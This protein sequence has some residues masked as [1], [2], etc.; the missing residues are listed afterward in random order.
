MTAPTPEK[1]D[2]D[3]VVRASVGL[4]SGVFDAWVAV[5]VTGNGV[6]GVEVNAAVK[7]G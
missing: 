2:W 1:P 3:S 7:V 4:G 5:D 6:T